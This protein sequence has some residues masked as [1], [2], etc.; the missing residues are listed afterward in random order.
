MVIKIG[1]HVLSDED[2]LRC[3]FF[4]AL[5]RQVLL[6]RK[7]GLNV[8][9]VSSGAIATAMTVFG[10]HTRPQAIAEKQAFAAIGQPLLMG[11]YLR[12][13]G[14]LKIPVAQVLLTSD[15]VAHRK[16][17]LNARHTMLKLL[18][19]GVVPIVNENDTVAV[20]EIK[21][22]DNDRLSASV[23][24]LI[25]ADLLLIL[26][27]VDGLYDSD[28]RHNPQSRLIPHVKKVD[29]KIE[30]YIFA[31]VGHRSV[32][33]MASKVLAARNCL[34]L[35]IPVFVTNGLQADVIGKMARGEK[36]RGTFFGRLKV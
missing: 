27:H 32:G 8:V 20:D 24:H 31:D 35:G 23:A 26:S 15:D 25:E 18:D 22:G 3:D 36:I 4:E 34:K 17:F 5:A 16:R 30:K 33:G 7:K 11:E 6:L 10:R 21:F 12:V 28:P 29:A 19:I 13:F 9:L 1:S 2:S 14:K